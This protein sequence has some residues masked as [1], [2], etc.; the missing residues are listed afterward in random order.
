MKELNIKPREYQEKIFETCKKDNCLVILPTGT[1][2]TLIAI[3]LAISRFKEFPLEKILVLAPT[4]PL[5]EQHF[6]SFKKALPE[7]WA[8]ME[9]FTGKTP[10]TTRKKIWRTCEFIF[11]TPQCVDGETIIFTEEGPVKISDF[12]T[13]FK[14]EKKDYGQ[15]ADTKEKVLG[16]DGKS[17]KFLEASKARKLHGNGLIK[18]KT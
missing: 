4:R 1:G 8:E 7:D 10:A 2:K 11:S 16:Y 17:I 9:I 15:V 13:K 18:I 14:V 6:N 3:M 12:F 5:V